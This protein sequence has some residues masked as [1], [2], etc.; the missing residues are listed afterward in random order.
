VAVEYL[1]IFLVDLKLIQM[2]VEEEEDQE[3]S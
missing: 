3:L 1:H 2:V